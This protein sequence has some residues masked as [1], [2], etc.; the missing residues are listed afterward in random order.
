M[1]MVTSSPYPDFRGP[2]KPV[3]APKPPKAPKTE[4]EAK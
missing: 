1:G 2:K 4:D 3:E